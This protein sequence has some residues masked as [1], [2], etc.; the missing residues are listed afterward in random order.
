MI[1]NYNVPSGLECAT[2]ELLVNCFKDSLTVLKNKKLILL[3][4][5]GEE[6]INYS[7]TFVFPFSSNIEASVED[8]MKQILNYEPSISKTNEELAELDYITPKIPCGFILTI[9]LTSTWGDKENIGIDH[10]DIL[11]YKGDSISEKAK[12][13]LFPEKALL[14]NAKAAPLLLSPF[15]NLKKIYVKPKKG[16]RMIIIFESFAMISEIKIMNYTK[17]PKAGAKEIKIFLDGNIIYEGEC[18]IG[19]ETSINF[20]LTHDSITKRDKEDPWSRYEVIEGESIK[21]LQLKG[22]E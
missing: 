5:P 12:I 21:I 8:V 20:S 14:S 1:Y 11:D 15:Q 3:K 7:Q 13:Y 9:Q 22:Y 19:G 17:I 16:N 18:N 2:R 4:P 6:G 10:I